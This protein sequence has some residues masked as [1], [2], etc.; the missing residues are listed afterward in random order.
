META[1]H[2]HWPVA[3]RGLVPTAPR[4]LAAKERSDR[5]GYSAL[6]RATHD[7]MEEQDEFEDAAEDSVIQPMGAASCSRSAPRRTV[8]TLNDD[9]DDDDDNAITM[10]PPAQGSSSSALEIQNQ[11]DSSASITTLTTGQ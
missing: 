8:Y 5:S 10:A 7:D 9:D 6:N 1:A 4:P 11:T 2:W 3:K